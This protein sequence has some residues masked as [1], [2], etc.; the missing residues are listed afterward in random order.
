VIRIVKIQS[1]TQLTMKQAINRFLTFFS[2]KEVYLKELRSRWGEHYDTFRSRT[3]IARLY[4]LTRDD[5]KADSVDDSTWHDLDMNSLFDHLDNTTTAI[6]RQ[7]LYRQLRTYGTNEKELEKQYQLAELFRTNELLRENVQLNMW[8]LRGTN[9]SVITTMLYGEMPKGDF[10]QVM[11]CCLAAFSVGALGIALYLPILFWLPI[12]SVGANFIFSAVYSHR[13]GRH[14]MSFV[15]LRDLLKVA[16]RLAKLDLPQGVNQFDYLKSN[17]RK[18]RELGAAFRIVGLDST[19]ANLAIAQLAFL[20]NLVCLFDFLIFI[21]C[22]RRLEEHRPALH[23]IYTTIA[24]IDS[25]ISI[26][27]YLTRNTHCCCPSF[28]TGTEMRFEQVAHPLLENAVANDYSS[29]GV[30]ALVTGSNMAGKSTF[31]KTIGV[32]AILAQT[33]RICHAKK[34]CVPKMPVISSIKHSDSLAHGKSYYFAEIDALL[35][36][37]KRKSN[38]KPHIFLIDEIL[39]GTNT[40]ERI[41]SS[42][43]ILEYLSENNIVLKFLQI[44]TFSGNF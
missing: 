4:V 9:S 38:G 35:Y 15:Y 28:V 25:A 21:R 10:P 5:K 13:I 41:A 17:R 24:S 36:L 8:R 1:S 33:V 30:S 12:V 11:A 31:I 27:S 37:I 14:S 32:N 19:S 39:H 22:V 43:A 20:M 29:D 2:I 40:I 26:G 16:K 6:G 7:Y 18:F 34:A 3:E 23:S 42:A 44:I